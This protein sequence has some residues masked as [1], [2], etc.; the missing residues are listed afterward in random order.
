MIFKD[1]YVHIQLLLNRFN[2]FIPEMELFF[3]G[4]FSQILCGHYRGIAPTDVQR[5]KRAG[6]I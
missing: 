3:Y 5:D 1:Q 4:L 2:L 6:L